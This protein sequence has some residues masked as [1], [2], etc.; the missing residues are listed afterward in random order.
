MRDERQATLAQQ[1]KPEAD[2]QRMRLRIRRAVEA[3]NEQ[4]AIKLALRLIPMPAITPE[5]LVELTALGRKWFAPELALSAFKRLHQLD[6]DN[7]ATLLALA[8]MEQQFCRS[9][10]AFRHL[11]DAGPRCRTADDFMRLGLIYDRL[12]DVEAARDAFQSSLKLSPDNAHT[13][14]NLAV[15]YGFL[16]DVGKAESIYDNLIARKFKQEHAS[17]NRSWLRKQTPEKN[18]VGELRALIKDLPQGSKDAPRMLYAL[19]KELDDLGNA[20]EAFKCYEAA[21]SAHRTSLPDYDVQIEL[22]RV[23][24]YTRHFTPEFLASSAEG[25]AS[26]EPIFVVSMPRAGSTLV[27][28]ILGRHSEVFAAGEIDN[29]L[30]LADFAAARAAREEGVSEPFYPS[31]HAKLDFKALGQ[32]YVDSTRPR[33]GHTRH[34]VDKLP[35][36][37]NLIGLIACVLPN[38][39]IVHVYRNPMDTCFAMYRQL[40]DRAYNYTYDQTE[41]GKA[42]LAYRR[43]MDHWEAVLPGK[44]IHVSYDELVSDTEGVAC[45]LLD[46][47]GLSWEEACLDHGAQSGLTKSASAVQVRGPVYQSSVGKWRQVE[48]ELAPL[49]EVLEAGGVETAH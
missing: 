13:Q 2:A 46:Q 42:Y 14:F 31:W 6:P 22:D 5:E 36:N 7:L 43:L 28:Q 29:L 23:E 30:R 33:T 48:R 20:E 47:L 38:A 27:E 1:F 40:F 3:G 4:E 24:E 12:G 34:F 8:G 17:Q 19:A 32:D 26:E 11:S 49:R 9:S 25:H 41:L 37:Y 35:T 16:G 10:D 18:H 45:D 21:A 39:K 15:C 44:I